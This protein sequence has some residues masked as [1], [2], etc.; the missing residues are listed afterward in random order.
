[1]PI[2][3]LLGKINNNNNNNHSA[4][5]KYFLVNK[6]KICHERFFLNVKFKRENSFQAL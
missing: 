3:E 6:R 4:R 2:N 1:M 5:V